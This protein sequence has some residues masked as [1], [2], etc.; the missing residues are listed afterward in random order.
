[1]KKYF[2][3][4]IGFFLLGMLVSAGPTTSYAQTTQSDPHQGLESQQPGMGGS[5]E[6]REGVTLS[7]G[8]ISGEVVS[9]DQEEGVI[10]IQTEQGVVNRFTVEGEAKEQLGQ[11]EQGDQVDLVMVL[12]ATP[13][14]G[15]M[16]SPIG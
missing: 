10:E 8:R 4:F 11:I 16:Q 14:E 2:F 5:P 3:A 12:R 13:Q 9:I 1:M 6:M 15:G 7:E